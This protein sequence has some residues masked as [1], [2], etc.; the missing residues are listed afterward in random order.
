MEFFENYYY[1][2]V[3][4][5]HIERSLRFLLLLFSCQAVSYSSQ[6]HGLQHTSFLCPSLFPGLFSIS[7]PL[8]QWCHLTISSSAALFFFCLQSFLASGSF[9]MNWLFCIKQPKYWSVSFSICPFNGYSGFISFRIDRFDLLAVQRDSQE[10]SPTPQFESI[11]SS[12]LVLL[13]G[14]TLTSIHAWL[15][16]NP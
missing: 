4:F 1:L 5:I 2:K 11:N 14:P 15:L 6:P 13:Y 12:A 7:D 8:S 3:Y 16:E 9:P 10:A